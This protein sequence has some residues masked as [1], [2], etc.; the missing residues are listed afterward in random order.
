MY[1]ARGEWLDNLIWAYGL[2]RQ[3]SAFIKTCQGMRDE[4]RTHFR[5]LYS[6]S[7]PDIDLLLDAWRLR[8]LDP[9]AALNLD[10]SAPWLSNKCGE[11]RN[12][13]DDNILFRR[14]LEGLEIQKA[15]EANTEN[16]HAFRLFLKYHQVESSKWNQIVQINKALIGVEEMKPLQDIVITEINRRGVIVEVMPTSNIRISHY[17]HFAQHHVIRWLTNKDKRPRPKVVIA[18][19]DPGIFA[20]NLRNEMS[21]VHWTLRTAGGLDESQA[22]HIV[23]RLHESA[24]RSRFGDDFD[25]KFKSFSPLRC[26]F[27]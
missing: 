17:E 4:I 6:E 25:R 3:E 14:P 2:L 5:K 24:R 26:H 22:D 23:E 9:L 16:P 19:D 10:G 27:R 12:K 7:T 8:H 11:I 18:S 20:T 13:E 15:R 1:C 21:L